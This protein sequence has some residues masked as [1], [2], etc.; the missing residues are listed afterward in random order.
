MLKQM[1]TDMDYRAH[2]K[3]DF[4]SLSDSQKNRFKTS[5]FKDA[6]KKMMN[7]ALDPAVFLRSFILMNHFKFTSIS[8]WVNEASNDDLYKFLVGT[9]KMPGISSHY[10]FINRIMNVD[11]H[12]TDLALA[13]LF[14]R[15][16]K[17]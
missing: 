6:M 8:E 7:L 9:D 4:N 13:G 2:L 12:R 17:V 14:L 3:F 1:S 10:D 5:S 15:K 16:N 11:P